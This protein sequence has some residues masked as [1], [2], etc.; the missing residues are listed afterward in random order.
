M[1]YTGFFQWNIVLLKMK[2]IQKYEITFSTTLCV[3]NILVYWIAQLRKVILEWSTSIPNK[4]KCYVYSS[5][6]RFGYIELILRLDTELW[7]TLSLIDSSQVQQPGFRIF[8][9]KHFFE[10]MSPAIGHNNWE[11]LRVLI[12][13]Y[14]EGRL[15]KAG[16]KLN[17]S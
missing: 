4:T 12:T 9:L 8:V 6:K 10:Q 16:L 2:E 1:K 11:I 17:S 15:C 13:S 3:H 14:L 5:C 7:L